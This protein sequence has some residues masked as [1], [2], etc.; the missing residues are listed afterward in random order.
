MRDDRRNGGGFGLAPKTVRIIH[1]VIRKALAYA[2]RKG[3]I[4]RNVADLRR[5]QHRH[6]V[7]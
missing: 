7:R 5:R 6:A 4:T 3:S 2:A 1:G